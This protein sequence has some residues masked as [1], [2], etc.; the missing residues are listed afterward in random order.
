MTVFGYQKGSSY[1]ENHRLIGHSVCTTLLP[2]PKGVILHGEPCT[3]T[4]LTTCGNTADHS[5]GNL[6]VLLGHI[7]YGC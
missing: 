1:T 4:E 6:T 7:G 5:I 3:T 2:I